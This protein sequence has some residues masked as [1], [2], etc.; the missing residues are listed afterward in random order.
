MLKLFRSALL[1]APL[2]AASPALALDAAAVDR[3]AR[4]IGAADACGGNSHQIRA[5]VTTV[6]AG[7]NRD[8]ATEAERRAFLER[9]RFYADVAREEYKLADGGPVPCPQVLE[10]FRRAFSR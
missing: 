2:L 9:F 8:A 5:A 1:A 3:L 4:L 10:E 7:I 6:E